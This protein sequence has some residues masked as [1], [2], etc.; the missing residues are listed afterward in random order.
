MVK[1]VDSKKSIGLMTSTML[2]PPERI[3]GRPN[4][5]KVRCLPELGAAGCNEEIILMATSSEDDR[6]LHEAKGRGKGARV[7]QG[8][9]NQAQNFRLCLLRLPRF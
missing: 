1:T 6:E 7:R 4:C 2:Q 3:T 8:F 5:L 9:Q